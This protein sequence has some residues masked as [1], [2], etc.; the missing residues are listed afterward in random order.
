MDQKKANRN[1]LGLH[2][3]SKVAE[4]FHIGSL[5]SMEFKKMS[6]QPKTDK[7]YLLSS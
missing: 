2:K 3:V 5:M 6:T 4:K 7:F 1:I